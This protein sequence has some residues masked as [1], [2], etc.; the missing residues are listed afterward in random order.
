MNPVSEMSALIL[1]SLKETVGLKMHSLPWNS[2]THVV[3]LIQSQKKRELSCYWVEL[4][5]ETIGL[6][7]Q[8][9]RQDA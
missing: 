8:K 6:E 3:S 4:V 2:R 1:K 7:Y 9:G 5:S